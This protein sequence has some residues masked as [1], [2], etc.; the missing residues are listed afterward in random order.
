MITAL[1][2]KITKELDERDIAYM[3][4]GSMA[5]NIYTIPR[6]TRDLDIVINLKL[7][8]IDSFSEIFRKRFYIY[9]EGIAKE[10]KNRG[11]FNVIDNDSGIK[12]DFIVR[13]DSEFHLNE[14]DRR[15]KVNAFGF[16]VYVVSIEDLIIS[17]INWIQDYKSE[18]QVGDIR[19]L[20]SNSEV[21]IEYVK[22]W[23]NKMNLKTYNLLA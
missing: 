5:M 22:K 14:F 21:D 16:E 12:I 2:E 18:V 20:L 19:N 17:K 23:C 10:I 15:K 7:S 9:K 11:M 6:M 4:S 13:K 8:D 1:L 3:L